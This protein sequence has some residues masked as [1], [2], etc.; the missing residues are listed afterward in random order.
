MSDDMQ[1][2][3]S[4]SVDPLPL[5]ALPTNGTTSSMATLPAS[6]DSAQVNGSSPTASYSNGITA[7]ISGP[8]NTLLSPSPSPSPSF[9]TALLT[10]STPSNISLTTATDSLGAVFVGTLT[11]NSQTTDPPLTAGMTTFSTFPEISAWSSTSVEHN[12]HDSSG[13][14]LAPWPECWFCPPGSHGIHLSGVWLFGIHLPP[15]PGLWPPFINW[16]VNIRFPT[17]TIDIHGN[18]SYPPDLNKPDDSDKPDGPKPD[19]DNEPK[20][21]TESTSKTQSTS[22]STSSE[23]SCSEVTATHYSVSCDTQSQT[24]SCTTISSSVVTSCSA[25][26]S[27]TTTTAPAC[28]RAIDY[29]GDQGANGVP[30]TAPACSLSIDYNEDQGS[31]GDP[32]SAPACDLTID[33]NENQGANGI[34]PSANS[35]ATSTTT[36]AS[37]LSA[38]SLSTTF[39]S[40]TSAS[41]AST[42]SLP[43]S[44]SLSQ[45]STSSMDTAASSSAAAA[46]I[47]VLSGALNTPTA[48]SSTS[49]T[50]IP[51]CDPADTS[52]CA[53]CMC[54]IRPSSSTTSS[55]MD[56]AAS[57]SIWASI[58]S[59]MSTASKAAA[60]S[61][62]ESEVMAH[63]YTYTDPPPDTTVAPPSPSNTPVAPPMPSS[64]PERTGHCVAR[65]GCHFAN[66][67]CF[68]SQDG[69]VKMS[70]AAYSAAVHGFCDDFS[71]L[72]PADNGTYELFTA[73]IDSYI[74]I[75]DV[76][77]VVKAEWADD[78][79]GCG[80]KKYFDYGQ[81]YGD[82][83][84]I[85]GT[86]WKSVFE[87]GFS[88]IQSFGGWSIKNTTDSGCIRFSLW[89]L[90]DILG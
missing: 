89:T 76:S 4:S 38:T 55:S 40:A 23:S 25:T 49:Q 48:T 84:W 80:P 5:T 2:L 13:I 20:S 51:F 66:V 71:G 53:T 56:A 63:T 26:A 6:S 35:T 68:P 90:P 47:S 72:D 70:A 52:S 79:T 36:M 74:T 1:T 45:S 24:A 59:V 54:I 85:C 33:Y 44:T 87:C 22:T 43:S 34:P 83:G 42:S 58:N 32:E 31:N 88:D 8:A 75:E 10:T 67:N 29:N 18:P 12:T 11:I 69:I 27:T 21:K 82:H 81:L 7:S 41:P 60:E 14:I 86:A 3:S 65:N 61:S 57:S 19:P 46:L 78:Q 15:P 73:H 16:I 37:I 77:V 62:R 9:S 30:E 28:T 64:H 39:L 17:I 50:S